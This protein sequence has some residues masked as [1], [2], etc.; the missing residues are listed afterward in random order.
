MTRL[1]L[2][3]VWVVHILERIGFG[4]VQGCIGFS[5]VLGFFFFARGISRLEH[6]V[7]LM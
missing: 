5:S 2:P 3:M 4:C 6:I 1:W 7:P